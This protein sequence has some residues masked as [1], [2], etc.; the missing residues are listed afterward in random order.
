V[1]LVVKKI[2]ESQDLDAGHV[3]DIGW[4][5]AARVYD[6]IAFDISH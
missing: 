1:L 5:V 6:Y 2:R 3:H 4:Q